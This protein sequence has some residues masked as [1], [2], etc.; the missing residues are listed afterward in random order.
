MFRGPFRTR[1]TS[2]IA[3]AVY[4][5]CMYSERMQIL[6][7]KDQRRRLEAEA[8]RRGTSVASVIRDALE[9]QLEVPTVEQRQ[10]AWER[11]KAMRTAARSQPT[12]TVD[13]IHELIHEERLENLPP[14]LRKKP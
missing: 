1:R 4:D 8:Q 5:V 9:R 3:R 12:L 13:E 10:A 14:F 2:T 6:I 7:S 11:L